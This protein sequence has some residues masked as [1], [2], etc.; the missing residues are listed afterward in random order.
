MYGRT[1]VLS[2]GQLLS[3]GVQGARILKWPTNLA[4]GPFFYGLGHAWKWGRQQ[5]GQT[6]GNEHLLVKPFS[7]SLLYFNA[8]ETIPNYS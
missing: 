4:Q 8:R 2:Q 1:W 7:W 5:K 6:L 3:L